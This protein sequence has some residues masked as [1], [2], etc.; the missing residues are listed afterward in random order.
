MVERGHGGEC[1]LKALTLGKFNY[2][3]ENISSICMRFH[4]LSQHLGQDQT[5]YSSPVSETKLFAISE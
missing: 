1:W 4:G 3:K 2:V 5:L